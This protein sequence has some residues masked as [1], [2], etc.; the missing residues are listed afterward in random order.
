[1]L[2]EVITE[3]G[4]THKQYDVFLPIFRTHGAAG[5]PV[6]GKISFRGWMTTLLIAIGGLYLTAVLITPYI[7]W[8]IDLLRP[9]FKSDPFALGNLE[10]S[11][12][13]TGWEALR[14][15]FV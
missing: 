7:G 11:V 12:N 1:M 8:N 6:W 4:G 15:N 14:N 10:A 2:Y 9:F 5:C 3:W 13:W